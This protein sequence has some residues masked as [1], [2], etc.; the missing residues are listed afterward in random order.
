MPQLDKLLAHIAPRGGVA[1]RLEPN[2]QPMLHLASGGELALLAN[3][4]PSTMLDLLAREVLPSGLA[5]AWSTRR[6]RL[7]GGT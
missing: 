6:L 3:P 1:L 5:A 4:L 2:Q 7:S